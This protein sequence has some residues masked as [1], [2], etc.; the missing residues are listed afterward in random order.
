MRSPFHA[1]TSAK[2]DIKLQQCMLVKSSPKY[3]LF[4]AKANIYI[5][6]PLL[7]LLKETLFRV[8]PK[9]NLY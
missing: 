2:V 7:Q 4:S 5:T 8:T 1:K 6:I 9:G 3:K